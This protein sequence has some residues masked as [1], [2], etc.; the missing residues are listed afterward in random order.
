MYVVSKK[1]SSVRV[2]LGAGAQHQAVIVPYQSYETLLHL[3][4]H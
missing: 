3:L 1:E 4:R 2:G